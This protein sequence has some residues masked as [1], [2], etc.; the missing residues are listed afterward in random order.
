MWGRLQDV[1]G[2]GGGRRLPVNRGSRR[3]LRVTFG[4]GESHGGHWR[5]RKWIWSFT[6]GEIQTSGG[7]FPLMFF[8]LSIISGFR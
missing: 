4:A 8:S 3:V 1:V 2:G 5:I 6:G 7:R